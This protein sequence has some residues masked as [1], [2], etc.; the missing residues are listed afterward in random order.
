MFFNSILRIYQTKQNYKK[1]LYRT[2]PCG[3]TWSQE[4]SPRGP[5]LAARSNFTIRYWSWNCR[6]CWHQAC[7][8]IDSHT[9]FCNL[10][11]PTTR[12]DCPVLLF[13]VTTSLCQ[14]WVIFA[15][16]AFLRCGSRFS[17]SLSGIEFQFSVTRHSPL[18]S[19]LTENCKLLSF[20]VQDIDALDCYIL[21]MGALLG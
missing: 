6:G 18:K 16:A 17:G 15:P 9:A 11:I 7:P 4:N 21:Y 20:Q 14:D 3:H 8:P 12:H 1:K 10:L 5:V 13:L 19:I 2:Q